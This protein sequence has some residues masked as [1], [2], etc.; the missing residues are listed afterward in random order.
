VVALAARHPAVPF[1]LAHIG[2]GGDYAHTFAV[3]GDA[4]NVYLDLSGSGVDRG[5][6]DGAIEAV[7]TRRLVWGAD[8]GFETALA[9]LWAL[10]ALGLGAD[11]V[12]DIRWRNAASIFPAGS[13]PRI[14]RPDIG[15][16]GVAPGEPP[17]R[18]VA[19][20]GGRRATT[21]GPGA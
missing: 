9:K 3:A 21:G 2:G 10:E 15:R 20:D 1:I 4:P 16:R 12:A 6:L 5:M 18:A 7:G 17:R 19:G 14:E 13:F 11:E 8:L